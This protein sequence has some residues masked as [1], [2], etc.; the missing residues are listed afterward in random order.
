MPDTQSVKGNGPAW[1]LPYHLSEIPRSL[2]TSAA[3]IISQEVA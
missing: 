1:I 3:K 2:D